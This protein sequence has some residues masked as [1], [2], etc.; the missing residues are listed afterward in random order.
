LI[1]IDYFSEEV[2][3]PFEVSALDDLPLQPYWKRRERLD[4]AIGHLGPLVG[5]HLG[6]WPIGLMVQNRAD[7]SWEIGGHRRQQRELSL[8]DKVTEN[9]LVNEIRRHVD[10]WRELRR[11]KAIDR[12]VLNPAERPRTP[13]APGRDLQYRA[14]PRQ[15]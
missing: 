1:R 2:F 15:S 10:Q 6:E 7:D 3:L 14:H 8:E 9:V 4:D 12:R 5:V 13:G 11:D